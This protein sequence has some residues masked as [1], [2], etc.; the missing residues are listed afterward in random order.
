MKREPSTWVY[1]WATLLLW[2]K[3][4]DLA[5]K[6]EGWKQGLLCEQNYCLWS[7]KKWKPDCLIQDK[8]GRIF[9]GRLWLRKGSF[10]NDDG[11]DDD[12]ELTKSGID[13]GQ[14]M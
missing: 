13:S 5:S 8:F 12:K 14:Q 4:R 10:A 1:N 9:E 6:D 7:P 11:D 3:Y 2:D